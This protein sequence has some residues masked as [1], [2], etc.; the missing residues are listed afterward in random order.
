MMI[1]IA[2]EAATVAT[3]TVATA[4]VGKEAIYA[5]LPKNRW[6]IEEAVEGI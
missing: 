2:A 1:L 5:Q 3:A 4:V 6:I